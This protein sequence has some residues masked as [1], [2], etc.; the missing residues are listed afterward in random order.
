MDGDEDAL[1]DINVPG[2]LGKTRGFGN[3][4]GTRGVVDTA[5]GIIRACVDVDFA[6]CDDDDGGG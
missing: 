5:G 3:T 2:T 6:V 1:D 4:V